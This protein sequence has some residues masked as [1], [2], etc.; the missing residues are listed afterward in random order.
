[1]AFEKG[2]NQ[3]KLTD[4]NINKIIETYRNRVDVDKYARV[5]SAEN[6]G[7]SCVEIDE[8]GQGYYFLAFFS[9][10]AWERHRL[11]EVM[12]CSISMNCGA[13]RYR[14]WQGGAGALP[15]FC[16]SFGEYAPLLSMIYS[17]R[18]LCLTY[19]AV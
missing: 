10:F 13:V 6:F 3:N 1:M 4:K 15:F 16:E 5:A 2:K 19:T 8:V 14:R 7:Y 17:F 18:C 11:G 12:P 9:Y